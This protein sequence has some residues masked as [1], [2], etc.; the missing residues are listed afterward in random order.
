MARIAHSKQKI[1]EL[2]FVCS[3][4]KKE[5]KKRRIT[6]YIFPANC[7]FLFKTIKVSPKV[8]N[9]IFLKY[10]LQ[11]KTKGYQNNSLII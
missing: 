6:V 10:Y 4:Y 5:E 2:N 3:I 11:R 9:N 7:V 1:N 8:K